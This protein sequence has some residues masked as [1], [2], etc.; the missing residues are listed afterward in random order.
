M[1]IGNKKYK[2]SEEEYVFGALEIYLNI[3]NVFQSVLCCLQ[4]C[5]CC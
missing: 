3:T 1:L 2:L 5:S 4:L